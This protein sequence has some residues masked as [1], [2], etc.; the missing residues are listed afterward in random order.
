MTALA[1]AL[2]AVLHSTIDFSLQIPGYAIVALSIIGAGVAQSFR[3][4]PDQKRAEVN[5]TRN[6]GIISSQTSL[7][8]S[9]DLA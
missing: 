1:I 3:E 5:D 8:S 4:Q 7:V 2:L 6:A 9:G